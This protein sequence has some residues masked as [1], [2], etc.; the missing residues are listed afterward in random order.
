MTL[1]QPLADG[2][3]LGDLHHLDRAESIAV[4]LIDTRDGL[5]L[6]DPGPASCLD[7]L[8]DV[9]REAGAAPDDVRNVLL[10]HIHLDHAGVVGTLARA[11]PRLRVHV[12][13]RGAKHLLDP[14]RLLD[15]A[16]RIYGDDMDRLWGEV[17]PV[18]ADQLVVLEGGE[19]LTIGGRILR[20]AWTPGHA[21]HHLAWLDERAGI[22]FTGDVAGEGTQHGTPALP[23]TPPPDIDL[24][25]WRPSLDLIEAWGAEALALTHFGPAREPATHLRQMWETLLLWSVSVHESLA[26]DGPDE[27]RA[28]AWAHTEHDR[29]TSPLPP[30]A[31]AHVLLETV[32]G[33]WYGLARYWRKKEEPPA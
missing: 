26:T 18:P 6:V 32:L 2:V 22:A 8:H 15:S 3:T 11:R 27:A 28:E 5:V 19:R 25:A 13:A 12:H 14:A 9:L 31:R 7:T 30:E 29:L 17:L 21:W 33:S 4:Y 24:E 1:L 16:R 20:A 23:V 10:T